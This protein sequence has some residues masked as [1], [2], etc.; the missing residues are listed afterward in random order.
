MTE[1]TFTKSYLST[2]DS[3]PLRL[4][5]DF[6]APPQSLQLTGPYTLPRMPNPMHKPSSPNDDPTT[7]ATTTPPTNDL[8]ITLKSQRNPPLDLK[9]TAVDPT[10]TSILDLKDRIVEEMSNKIEAKKVKILYARKPVS[11]TKTISEAVGADAP[12]GGNEVEFA[13]MVMGWSGGVPVKD[14]GGAGVEGKTDTEKA[15]EVGGAGKGEG[16][17]GVGVGALEGKEFW[18]DL[19]GFLQQRLKDEGAAEEVVG[20]FEGA[21]RGRGR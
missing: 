8:T 12:T 17:Q 19:R 14:G 6:I 7:A 13:V 20:V 9:L 5:P 10:T 4:Q 16:E 21:W 18:G 1:L 11:D 3:R 15:E 2:L